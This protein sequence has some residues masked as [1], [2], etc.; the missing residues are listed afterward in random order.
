M[1]ILQTKD[2]PKQHCIILDINSIGFKGS[3][4]KET[5]N[6]AYLLTIPKEGNIT[7]T[8]SDK[9]GVF[10]GIQTL[11]SLTKN[12]KVPVCYIEDAPRYGILFSAFHVL[13]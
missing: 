1:K 9:A 6:E 12:N 3:S 8:G 10:Y 13:P 7:I 5:T 4:P 11:I 2:I